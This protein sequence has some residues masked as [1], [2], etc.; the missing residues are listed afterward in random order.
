MQTKA[1]YYP[2]TLEDLANPEV[3]DAKVAHIHT[4]KAS[5]RSGVTT[6][7]MLNLDTVVNFKALPFYRRGKNPF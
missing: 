6:P 2:S 3:G 4:I 1:K 5:M 7:L